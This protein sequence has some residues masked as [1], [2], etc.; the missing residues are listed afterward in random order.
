LVV[1]GNA[2]NSIAMNPEGYHHDVLVSFAS[3]IMASPV[4][5]GE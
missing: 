3:E 4:N 2:R 1:I 5:I